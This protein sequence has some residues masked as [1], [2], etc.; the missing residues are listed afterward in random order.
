MFALACMG[1]VGKSNRTRYY[2]NKESKR[3][4]E[5]DWKAVADYMTA[6][7]EKSVC[8]CSRWMW[9][10]FQQI[11]ALRHSLFAKKYEIVDIEEM[12]KLLEV[13]NKEVL[14]ER[15]RK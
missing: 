4:V 8:K 7:N 12:K 3:T 13:F 5:D 11:F 1:S 10:V 9:Y 14:Y 15:L 6:L 2:K